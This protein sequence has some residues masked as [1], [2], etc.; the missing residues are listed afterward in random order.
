MCL[1]H[2]DG[3]SAQ[4]ACLS[5]RCQLLSR[6]VCHLP[7][8]S[9]RENRPGR[10]R[11]VGVLALCRGR[12]AS[13]LAAPAGRAAG[14]PG[15]S[16]ETELGALIRPGAG[17]VRGLDDRT[18]ELLGAFGARGSGKGPAQ[19]AQQVGLLSAVGAGQQSPDRR[20]HD[21]HLG[22]RRAH[23]RSGREKSSARNA[24]FAVDTIAADGKSCPG[25]RDPGIDEIDWR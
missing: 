4:D 16:A 14:R 6:V 19:A 3:V 18:M 10:P 24:I 7:T 17:A 11:P 2:V 15:A 25:L 5:T 8:P 1:W 22:A 21:C 9:S 12:A 13:G 20:A 23:G